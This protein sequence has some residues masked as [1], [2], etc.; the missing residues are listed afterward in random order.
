MT[1]RLPWKS[2]YVDSFLLLTVEKFSKDGQFDSA[3]AWSRMDDRVLLEG[4]VVIWLW[5]WNSCSLMEVEVVIC[6]VSYSFQKV[7][8]KNSCGDILFLS[9]G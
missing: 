7:N 9:I 8:S 2:C 3:K 1:A 6:S 5:D 4:R